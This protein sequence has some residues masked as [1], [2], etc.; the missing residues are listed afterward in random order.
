MDEKFILVC[1]GNFDSVWLDRVS[2]V[3]F[4]KPRATQSK[5]LGRNQ[6]VYDYADLINQDIEQRI[7][8]FLRSLFKEADIE[9]G[10]V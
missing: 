3:L 9:N 2:A 5:R 7:N 8:S 1:S 10:R 6:W 4:V